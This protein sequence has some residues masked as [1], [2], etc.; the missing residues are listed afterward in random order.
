MLRLLLPLQAQPMLQLQLELQL[1]LQPGVRRAPLAIRP[2]AAR[3]ARVRP[4]QPRR[5]QRV[6][7]RAPPARH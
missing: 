4:W 3:L 1:Q 7:E 2:A 6:F 5:L